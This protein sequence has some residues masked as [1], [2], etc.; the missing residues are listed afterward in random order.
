[1][2]LPTG[3]TLRYSRLCA[4]I[5]AAYPTQD[6]SRATGQSRGHTSVTPDLARLV[7]PDKS[8]ATGRSRGHTSVTPDLARLVDPAAPTRPP[9]Q[10]KSV[11]IMSLADQGPF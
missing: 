7:D 4:A 5:R 1:M 9:L 11:K 8:R 10:V 6:K 2:L 3:W